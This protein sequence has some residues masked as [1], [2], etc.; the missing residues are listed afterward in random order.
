[1]TVLPLKITVIPLKITETLLK[2]SA[3]SLKIGPTPLEI[4]PNPSPLKI[5]SA[6]EIAA[7]TL[8]SIRAPSL[9]VPLPPDTYWAPPL[10]KHCE[11]LSLD[12][13]RWVLENCLPWGNY[14]PPLEN[15]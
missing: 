5:N 1:M 10:E 12:T 9:K 14:Y 11:L 4:N 7:A 3:S 2:I 8:K 6:C 15:Y 13:Y